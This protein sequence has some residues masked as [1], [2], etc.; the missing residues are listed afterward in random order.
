M[1]ERNNHNEHGNVSTTPSG[2]SSSF[3]EALTG[4]ELNHYAIPVRQRLK[5]LFHRVVGDFWYTKT[6][7]LQAHADGI[8]AEANDKARFSSIL[9][10]AAAKKAAE[11]PALV[12][13][14]I[15]RHTSEGLREQEHLEQLLKNT[16]NEIDDMSASGQAESLNGSDAPLDEDWLTYFLE[17]AK[18]KSAD[19]MKTY[20]SKIMAGEI[21]HPGSFSMQTIQSLAL[22]NYE[23]G[24]CFQILCR[25][26]IGPVAHLKA[27]VSSMNLGNAA[28]NVLMPFGLSFPVLNI[29]NEHNLIIADTNSY[30][31]Y[32][33]L[34]KNRIVFE[35]AGTK[36]LIQKNDKAGKDPDL[37]RCHGVAFTRSG[38]ELRSIIA[39]EWNVDYV[40]AFCHFLAENNCALLKVIESV[41]G[42]GKRIYK[43]SKIF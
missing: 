21:R 41:D 11:N 17:I 10:E 27:F 8:R 6:A 14:Y 31:S 3:L 36:V 32:N 23:V 33:Y 2:D 9:T 20:L 4:R 26:S 34:W 19:H 37:G 40:K 16:V 25:L 15:E 30:H 28:S 5:Q 18:T 13:R 39:M 1:A 24:Q 43:G 22:F 42:D 38:T 7:E 35:F 12:D 29:L